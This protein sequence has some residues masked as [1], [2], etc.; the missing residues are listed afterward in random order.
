LTARLG[1]PWSRALAQA[2]FQ[3]NMQQ[4][5][6]FE[7]DQQSHL[8]ISQT[9]NDTIA[10]YSSPMRRLADLGSDA[11]TQIDALTLLLDASDSTLAGELLAEY[12]SLTGLARASFANLLRF[13]P[14]TKAARLVAALRL[15]TLACKDTLTQKH[16]DNPESVYNTFGPEMRALDREVLAVLLLN[17]RF[18][19]IKF[20]RLSQGT[21]N[22]SLAHPREILK[23]AIIH[24]AYAFVLVHNHPSGDANPSD[25]D[26]RL[27]RSISLA[28]ST[29]QIQFLDHLIM[30]AP[31]EGRAGYFSF[32]EAGLL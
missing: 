13:L 16:F 10:L 32:K 12:G 22:E 9:V 4:Q 17:T 18:R 26:L 27:T 20:E 23:P 25:T 21:V 30:G 29:M 19:L 24:S 5:F 14:Q 3:K 7:A 28:A 31:A 11:L 2:R 6:L 1:S 15:G 8:P